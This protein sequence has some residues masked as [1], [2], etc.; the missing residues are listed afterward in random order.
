VFSVGYELILFRVGVTT[1]LLEDEAPFRVTHALLINHLLL[2]DLITRIMLG[3]KIK[4]AKLPNSLH[5]P[6]TSPLL[7][8]KYSQ[9]PQY[10]HFS[11]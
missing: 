10:M 7:N 8:K 2:F 3:E 9:H 4:I 11:Q 6:V 1:H 5:S